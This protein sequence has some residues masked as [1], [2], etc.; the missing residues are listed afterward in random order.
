MKTHSFLRTIEDLK[1]GDH[2]CSIYK[3]DQ[4]YRKA[5]TLFLRQG[6]KRNEKLLYIADQDQFETIIGYFRSDGIEIDALLRSGQLGGVSLEDAYRTKGIFDPDRII[7]LIRRKTEPILLEGYS[8]LRVTCDLTKAI[9]GLHDAGQV[10]KYESGLNAFLTGSP[11][12]VLCLYDRRYLKPDLL[13]SVLTVHPKVLIETEVIENF[14]YMPPEEM[15]SPDVS[16][17]NLNRWL[18]NLADRKRLE[19][20][21]IDSEKHYRSFFE[22]SPISLWEEDLSDVKQHIVQL[23]KTGVKDFEKYFKTHPEEVR[24]CAGLVNIVDV[25]EATLPLYKANDK[26]ELFTSLDNVFGEASYEVFKKELI[27]IAEGCLTFEGEAVN[28][29]LTG[30]TVDLSLKWSVAPGHEQSLSKILVSII[31]VT[32][33]KRAEMALKE[34]EN[35]F[36]SIIENTQAGYFLID[37]DGIIQN[38]NQALAKLYG[39]SAVDEIVGRHFNIFQQSVDIEHAKKMFSGLKNGDQQYLTGELSRKCKDG[40]TG[41]HVFSARPVIHSQETTGIEAFIIDTT[42]RRYL[43]EAL[44]ESEKKYRLLFEKMLS[45]FAMLEMVC[46]ENKH[47]ADWRYI[48]VN[49]SHER[50]TGLKTD[51]V[52]GR[53]VR[54]CFPGLEDSWFENFARVEQTGEPMQITGYLKGLNSWQKLFVYRPKPGFIAFTFENITDAKKAELEKKRLE[55]QIRQGQ[56]ME[57]I[58]TLA[59]GIAHDFNNILGIILG[60]AELA[61]TETVKGGTVHTRFEEI[62]KASLRARELI[63]EILNFSRKS[64]YIRKPVNVVPIAEESLRMLRASIPKSIEI[65]QSFLTTTDTVLANPIQINQIL[66]NLCTN[67]VQAMNYEG[68]LQ[69]TIDQGNLEEKDIKGA[70]DLNPGDYL[71]ISVSDTGSGIEPEIIDKIFDPYFTTKAVGKGAGMGLAVVYGIVKSHDGAITVH[72]KVGNGSVF[73]VFLP[74]IAHVDKPA[75]DELINKPFPTGTE[76]ILFVDDEKMLL[77]VAKQMLSSLGYSVNCQNDPGAALNLFRS[78]PDTFDLVITDMTMHG[79]SGHKLAV[80]LMK[81]RSDIPIILC[82]GFSELIDEDKAMQMGIK[83]FLIKPMGIRNLAEAVREVLDKT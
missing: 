48:E 51:K 4:E 33:R 61:L 15:L 3:T 26:K 8:A 68:I 76:R 24:L 27:A 62:K 34:S 59:G 35:R 46:D 36:R 1:P 16:V 42:E 5:V 41:Y 64:Q 30:E 71:K 43:E 53:T 18:H 82:T 44:R 40:S 74:V 72:S 32:E 81:I 38:A 63:M 20:E 56:K 14:Y 12:L 58:G 2:V 10:I 67:A 9:E 65:R 66:I 52:I 37:K 69:I 11:C 80:E 70:Q 22:N 50:L 17:K 83:K 49:P 19:M 78:N 77:A 60:N 28:K 6:L 29:T 45:G 21:L 25:N 55:D 39:F 57:A 23:K 7:N 31:D 75:A 79:L 54:E 13:L 73:N 47:P